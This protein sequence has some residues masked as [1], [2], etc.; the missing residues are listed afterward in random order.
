MIYAEK[1]YL[2][3]NNRV[4]TLRSAAV[5]DAAVMVEFLQITN[6]E[7]YF[8]LRY[9]EKIH[10]EHQSWRYKKLL[11]D[12]IDVVLEDRNND[13]KKLGRAAE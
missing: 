7:T 1:E 10:K 8:M 9:P 5:S 12:Q 13:L 3:K 4:C 2:L 6:E 11:S